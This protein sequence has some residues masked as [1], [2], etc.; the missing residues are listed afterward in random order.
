MATNQRTCAISNCEKQKHTKGFCRKHYRESLAPCSF[1]GCE[2]VVENLSSW[3]CAGHYSQKL[4]GVELSPLVRKALSQSQRFSEKVKISGS[5]W[6]W[7]GS[8]NERGYGQFYANGKFTLAHR[9]SYRESYGDIPEGF[10]VDHT[11]R[12]RGCVNPDHLRLATRKQNMENVGNSYSSSKSGIR[13]VH[14]DQSKNLWVAQ[15]GHSN[16]KIA[17]RFKTVEEASDWV[18]QKRIEVFTHNI[19]DRAK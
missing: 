5:C 16:R 11:C 4:R 14:F 8:K 13:G 15:V 12:N 1:Q 10:E 19:L 6:L 9:Y 18:R 17:R 2:K 3:L 7:G